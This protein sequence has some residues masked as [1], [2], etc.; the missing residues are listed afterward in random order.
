M[1]HASLMP[2]LHYID[3]AT[4]YSICLP[5][6]YTL[7]PTKTYSLG[8]PTISWSCYF[9]CAH[10]FPF[11]STELHQ[12]HIKGI[13]KTSQS[14][15]IFFQHSC[16]NVKWGQGMLGRIQ[17]WRVIWFEDQKPIQIDV[18]INLVCI[19][20]QSQSLNPNRENQIL[21]TE[22][23]KTTMTSGI[24]WCLHLSLGN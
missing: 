13:F 2:F 18:E 12:F 22:S 23:K 9:C 24:I 3:F 21:K 20:N 7:D 15:I 1:L 6:P 14:S 10:C 8:P 4:L 17:T 16:Q 5:R 19:W 11:Q